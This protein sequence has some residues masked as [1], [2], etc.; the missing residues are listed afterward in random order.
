MALAILFYCPNWCQIDVFSAD[1]GLFFKEN[2]K[3]PDE[4]VNSIEKS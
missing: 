1:L 4:Q 3:P 2:P